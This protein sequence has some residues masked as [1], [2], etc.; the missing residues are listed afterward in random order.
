VRQAIELVGIVNLVLFAAIAV[1]CVRQWSTER[2]PT[3]LWAALAFVTLAGVIVV[4]QLL[5]DEPHGFAEKALQR[6]DIAFL[7]LFP[8][9]LYRFA[10]AFE[11]TK[12]PLAPYIDVLTGGL[13]V[14]TFALPHVP[15]SGDSWPWWF[16]VY[17]IAFVIHWSVLLLIVAVRLW[18]AGQTEATVARRRMEMLAIASTAITAALVLAAVA[19][20]EDSVLAL[21]T[22]LLA[23][24]S[25][26][27]FML[28]FAPPN[29]LR[30]LWRRPE[31]QRMQL[32]IGELMSATSEQEV[33]ERVLPAMARM[34]GA[35]G[36]AV[37]GVDG[38]R[39][40]EHGS[41]EDVSNGDVRRLEFPF[42]TLVIRTSTF[43]PFFGAEERKLLTALGS[44]MSLALDRA[45]LFTQERSARASLE[46]VDELKSQFVSLA[47][48]EL[49]SPVGAIYGLSETLAERK[50]QLTA[51]QVAE[52]ETSLTQQIR[53]LRTLVEQLLDLS[54]LDAEA[55]VIKPQRRARARAAGRDRQRD[56]SARVDLD[57]DR[58]RPGARGRGR[59]ARA[60]P[61]RHEPDRE[62]LPVR[63]AA[64]GGEC[65]AGGRAPAR[66]GSGPWAR[67]A[68]RVRATPVRPLCTQRRQ[69]VECARHRPGAGNRPFLCACPQRRDQLPPGGLERL[70]VRADAADARCLVAE[71]GRGGAGQACRP[72]PRCP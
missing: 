61:D 37:D 8:Y 31:Q 71:I 33:A 49:R 25:A 41:V 59:R 35:R 23:T 10:V 52:L 51:L 40:A 14:A 47:A 3:A 4:G 65:G 32:A 15:A 50:H 9:L 29:A 48:H 30:L 6:L 45:R 26:V 57:R 56:R 43:A 11:S 12:R 62:C 22:G 16:A 7:V 20:D 46:R 44:L 60:R 5:P 66:D 58:S 64:C 72:R 42:G 63:R 34:V 1:V 68:A 36:I 28:G 13:V 69:R 55:V 53:R 67:G 24:F 19:G 17:V 39:L 18:R 2:A 38:T 54:R 27:A 21:V 70:G